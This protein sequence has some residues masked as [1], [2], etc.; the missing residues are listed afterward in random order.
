MAS[1]YTSLATTPF[2]WQAGL[3]SGGLRDELCQPLSAWVVTTFDKLS[4]H[5]LATNQTLAPGSDN[6]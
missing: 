1:S 2:S 3:A 4:N 6:V 5:L